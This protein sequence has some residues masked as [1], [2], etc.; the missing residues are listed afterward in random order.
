MKFGQLVGRV[1]QIIVVSTLISL[2]VMFVAERVSRLF[3]ITSGLEFIALFE[4]WVF[5]V[6]GVSLLVSVF[7]FAYFWDRVNLFNLLGPKRGWGVELFVGLLLGIFV[8]LGAFMLSI[9]L[10]HI[11]IRVIVWDNLMIALLWGLPVFS[12]GALA[13]ELF[14][15][16]YIIGHWRGRMWW[17]ILFSS[18]VFAITHFDQISSLF[19]FA[20]LLLAG[21]AFALMYIWSGNLWMPIGFH[22]AWNVMVLMMTGGPIFAQGIMRLNYYPNA[23]Y[24]YWWIIDLG[25]FLLSIVIAWWFLRLRGKGCP[26]KGELPPELAHTA[27]DYNIDAGTAKE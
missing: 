7:V 17:A 26:L 14:Y 21:I 20:Y 15:R 12:L 18:V 1:L 13:E 5:W 4:N 9:Y 6:S 27:I 8:P 22:F 19:S 10:G 23:W 3:G 24:A 25:L 11:S 2:A 16:G